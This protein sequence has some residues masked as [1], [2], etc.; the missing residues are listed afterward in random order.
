M[1]KKT[2]S[3]NDPYLQMGIQLR[4][5]RKKEGYTIEELAEILNVSSKIISNYENGYNR[6]T[7]DSILNIYYSEFAADLD[8]STLSEIFIIDIFK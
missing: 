2:I 5:L 3:N 8:L 4:N 7:L 1:V 6:M